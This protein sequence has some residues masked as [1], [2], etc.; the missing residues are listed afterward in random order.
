MVARELM[1]GQV[2]TVT[3]EDSLEDVSHRLQQEH[4]HGA[5]VASPD[6][7]LVGFVTQGDVLFGSLGMA[8]T[9]P[10]SKRAKLRVRDVMTSPAVACS[11]PAIRRSEVVFPQPDGPRKLKNEPRSTA[12]DTSSTATMSPKRLVTFR[13]SISM[14]WGLSRVAGTTFLPC[15]HIHLNAVLLLS[16][17]TKVDYHATCIYVY[18][19]SDLRHIPHQAYAES[20]KPVA[21]MRRRGPR[22]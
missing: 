8:T 18:H 20:G 9:E 17:S 11:K 2:I 14:A 21:Q 19:L 3:E 22:S 1:Q 7:E 13:N 10:D 6:G 16:F 12:R 4:V 5:P 15:W